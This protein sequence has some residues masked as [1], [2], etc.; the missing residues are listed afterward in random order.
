MLVRIDSVADLDAGAEQQLMRTLRRQPVLLRLLHIGEQ[1]I[2]LLL[3]GHGLWRRARRRLPLP[4]LRALVDVAVD[5][6]PSD[7]ERLCH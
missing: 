7:P 2:E 3:C 5:G 6:L 4:H 1:L